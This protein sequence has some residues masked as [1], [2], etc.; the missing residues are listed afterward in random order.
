M[1]N[2]LIFSFMF[3]AILC[4]SQISA[5]GGDEGEIAKFLFRS[6]DYSRVNDIFLASKK[7]DHEAQYLLGQ[8]F[9]WGRGVERDYIQSKK[10]YIRSADGGYS[11]AQYIVANYMLE[12]A[13]SY[14]Q[15]PSL[16]I[17]YLEKAAI[18]KHAKAICALVD[19][20]K[21]GYSKYMTLNWIDMAESV[22]LCN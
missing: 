16:S 4:F 14:E 21:G 13:F 8:A 7:G 6:G 2:K 18:N 1:P 11:E 9:F 19:L 12:G 3:L 20:Q 17:Q 5:A 22:G 10:W 15:S